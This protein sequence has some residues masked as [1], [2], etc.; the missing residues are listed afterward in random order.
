MDYSLTWVI[1]IGLKDPTLGHYYAQTQNSTIKILIEI[2]VHEN[3][4]IFMT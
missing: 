4:A 2:K 3:F 1:I